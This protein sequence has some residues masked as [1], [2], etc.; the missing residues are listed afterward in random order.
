MNNFELINEVDLEL[1]NKYLKFF[2]ITNPVNIMNI[3]LIK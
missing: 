3:N 2:N 1:H